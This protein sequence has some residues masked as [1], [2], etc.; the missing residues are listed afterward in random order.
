MARPIHHVDL[1]VSDL[2]RSR[3]FYEPVMRYLGYEVTRETSGEV[4]YSQAERC[5]N[6]AVRL[7]AT[8]PE[9]RGKRHDRYAP[10]VHHLAF[11]AESRE[12]VD[13]LHLL[14][15]ELNA[16]ILDPPGPYDPPGYY[17]LS[18]AD[19]DGLKLELAFTP[20]P[21]PTQVRSRTG[22]AK[23]AVLRKIDCV[24]VKVENL[25][26]AQR[27][28]ERVLGLTHL[29]S[30][31]HSVALGMR[32]CDAEIV[33]HDDPKIPR[34]CNVHYLVGDVKEAAAKLSSAGC[35]VMVAPFQVRI[36]MCAVLRDPFENLLNLID[37]SKG[38][39][40]YGLL[41]PR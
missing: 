21:H 41:E 24:M 38:P 34:E 14:L 6:T 33:L 15:R 28:Y 30:N 37:M 36:G 13:G 11:D 25:A 8:K 19:P 18:F 32:D 22:H 40:E 39:I 26:A 7:Y 35:A 2:A 12:D 3:T 17:A 20:S 1:T 5:A 29:W 31:A 27:F 10:G 4:V 23:D 16:E 9:S